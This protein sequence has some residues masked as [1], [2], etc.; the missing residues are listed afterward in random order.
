MRKIYFSLITL[1]VFFGI[2]VTPTLAQTKPEAVI[3][4]P[5]FVAGKNNLVNKLVV[6]DLMVAGGQSEISSTIDG[7]TYVASGQ[8]NISGDISGNLIVAGGDITISGNIGR[9]LIVAG[10][11]VI[12]N[13]SSSVNG[14][15]LVAGGKVDLQGKFLGPVKVGAGTLSIGNG[16]VINGKLEADVSQ[17]NISQNAQI[18]GTKTINIHEVKQ[19]VPPSK[20]LL[21]GIGVAKYVYGFLSSLVVLLVFIKLLSETT[22]FKKIEFDLSWPILGWGLIILIITPILFLI[23]MTTIIG[24][25]LSFMVLA[26]YLTV[27]YLSNIIVAIAVGKLITD[28]KILK[29]KNIYLQGIVGLLLLSLLQ[30]VPI[31]GGLIKFITVILGI[32]ILYKQVCKK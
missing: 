7:D 21:I 4:L 24:M 18:L 31:I 22:K 30:L 5:T 13:N 32:G 26:I 12:L 19:P 27:L 17:S 11:Q 3:N 29:I 6:G 10:G 25:P 9:N 28:K 14:Y 8:I 1:F 23:L 20:N 2:F 15:M 16:A